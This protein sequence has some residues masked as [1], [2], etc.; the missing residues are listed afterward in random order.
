MI[1]SRIKKDREWEIRS[2][3]RVKSVRVKVMR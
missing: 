1:F 3:E 2:C